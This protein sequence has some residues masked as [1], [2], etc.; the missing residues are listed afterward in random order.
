MS[1]FDKVGTK[2][3]PLP[4]PNHGVGQMMPNAILSQDPY[5]IKAFIAFRFDPI[6]SI[7]D[8]TLTKKALDKLDLIVAI[9]INYSDI[10]WYA[11]VVLPESTYLERSDCIQQANGLKPQMFLRKQAVAPRYDTRDGAMILKQIAER[12]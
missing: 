2:E 7:P 5:P 3:F 11:D 9:D 8:T 4:D 10:A 12:I 1:R 6:G